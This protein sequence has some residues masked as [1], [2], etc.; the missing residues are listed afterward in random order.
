M[1]T[2]IERHFVTLESNWGPRQVHYRRAGNGPPVLMLHQSLKSSR[3]FEPLMAQWAEHFTVIAPDTPGFG[4]S[5]PLPVSH[6]TLEDL[7][8]CVIEFADALELARF[9]VYGFHSGGG[10]AVAL[11]DAYP[12]RVCCVAVNG[13]VM[14]TPDERTDI[15]Q[16]YLPAFEPKWDGSHLTWLW[17][18]M[19]EQTIFFPWFAHR[20]SC[21]MDYTMP[22]P[23]ALQENLRE[24]LQSG[25]HYRAGYR[26]AFEYDAAPAL[27]RT[28]MP[29][30]VTAARLD[31][32]SR[33]LQRIQDQ[34]DCVEVHES[35]DAVEAIAR[36]LDLLQQHGHGDAPPVPGTRPLA[37][38]HW[39]DTVQINS[40]PVRLLRFGSE[41]RALVLH[42]AA[43]S[44]VSVDW[45]VRALDD[46]A[47][48][49][50]PG[51][52]E[53]ARRVAGDLTV[54]EC[55]ESVAE[56]LHHLGGEHLLLAGEGEGA[57]LAVE[58][59]RLT[60]E[61]C[62]GLLLVNPIIETEEIGAA[63]LRD[64]L[65]SMAPDWH[66]GHLSRAWHC[67][68]DGRLFHPWFM[69]NPDGIRWQEPDLEPTRL[70][71][72]VR[73]L[74]S[75]EGHWQAWVRDASV[76]PAADRIAEVS[77]P[78]SIAVSADHPS[79][80]RISRWAREQQ[81]V[82]YTVLPG[83]RSGWAEAIKQLLQADRTAG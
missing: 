13:L 82:G 78:V 57:W 66:G 41:C 26:A 52:G 43:G 14:P 25:D 6:T 69:R 1:S 79:K 53:H 11:A 75:S 76:Y 48:M 32:L 29:T 21:R 64:G 60:P 83:D 23:K 37:G 74:M 8:A 36:A 19:R 35:A 73:E 65:P 28:K 22:A 58:V 4:Q 45:L 67:V 16:H 20:L 15:L 42:G 47:A 2:N 33:H 9:S 50:L 71:L 12:D 38:R 61:R 62:S 77:V 56:V 59:A 72:E 7:A 70:T 49:D 55:A 3:E 63:I 44:A 30:L 54:A 10:I 68:R 17:A 24:A 51:H 27:S 31:P 40:G 34:A 80:E 39:Q 46:A 81:A 18:R 5:D